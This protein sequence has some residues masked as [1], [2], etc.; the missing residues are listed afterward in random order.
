MNVIQEIK[1][2]ALRSVISRGEKLNLDGFYIKPMS[3]NTVWL[4]FGINPY[5]TFI[6]KNMDDLENDRR[7]LEDY[8]NNIK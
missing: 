3:N 8:V 7:I 2:G 4:N 1:N 6:Y 5:R